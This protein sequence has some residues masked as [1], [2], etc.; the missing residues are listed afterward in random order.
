MGKTVTK[1][2][3]KEELEKLF[4]YD[5]D[6]GQLF[7]KVS[8]GK[9]KKG[10]VAGSLDKKHGYIRVRF[11]GKNYQ[12]HRIV[13][14]LNNG[15][16]PEGMYIDHIDH[17][18]ENN[19][20]QNLRLVTGYTNQKNRSLGK[21]NRSGVLGVHYRKERNK[22]QAT[23]NYDHNTVFLGNFDDWFEA[24]CARKSA[25]AAN[26]GFHENHGRRKRGDEE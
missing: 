6:T 23:I 24:V 26:G 11:S 4:R 9:A 5:P 15:D 21:N 13:W 7:W 14:I 19:R 20:L 8:A 16:I 17:N 22:W 2:P 12:A 1:D 3:K 10:S 25:E 18:K